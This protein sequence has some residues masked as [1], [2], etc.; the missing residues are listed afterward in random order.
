M[1][2]KLFKNLK[3]EKKMNVYDY[4]KMKA[5]RDDLTKAAILEATAK[6]EI[7]SDEGKDLEFRLSS[8]KKARAGERLET[9]SE[10]LLSLLESVGVRDNLDCSVVPGGVQVGETLISPKQISKMADILR[11][12]FHAQENHDAKAPPSLSLVTN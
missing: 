12:V 9:D 8:R 2:R 3:K 5:V 4:F 1:F 7:T 11:S 6:G 10:D